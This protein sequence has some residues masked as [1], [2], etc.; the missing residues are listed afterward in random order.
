MA[1]EI[2]RSGGLYFVPFA[3][4][5]LGVVFSPVNERG[6]VECYRAADVLEM[7]GVAAVLDGP[8]YD[9]PSAGACRLAYLYYDRSAGL[10]GRWYPG[11]N[12]TQGMTF[13][14]SGDRV[15]VVHGGRYVGEP[16]VAVQM[17]PELVRAGRNV[18]SS[19]VNTHREWRAG[20]GLM[21]DGQM[22]FAVSQGSMHAFAQ[23]LVALGVVEAG[24]TDGGGS[25]TLQ[26]GSERVGHPDNRPVASWLVVRDQVATT[27]QPGLS[28][29]G[30]YS[31]LGLVA[32]LLLA[33]YLPLATK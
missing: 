7:P 30:P 12:P 4:S 27:V 25:T 9:E 33:P 10:A 32:P 17:Y 31:Y 28:K 15:E 19:T 20:L 22:I 6:D 13:S 8:M 2:K 5:R 26:V 23:Q 24:Y 29:T 14:I 3:P 11:R 18:A 16:D 1:L 21:P